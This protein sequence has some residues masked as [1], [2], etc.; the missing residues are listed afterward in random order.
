MVN[1]N[2]GSFTAAYN[3]KIAIIIIKN[4]QGACNVLTLQYIYKTTPGFAQQKKK[5]GVLWVCQVDFFEVFTA[6]IF[7]LAINNISAQACAWIFSV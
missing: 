4:Q 5:E 2:S 6:L 3:T 7:F 1:Q